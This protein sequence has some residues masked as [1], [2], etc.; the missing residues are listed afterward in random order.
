MINKAKEISI[1]VPKTA[2]LLEMRLHDKF[3]TKVREV[4]QPL[5]LVLAANQFIDSSGDI[6]YKDCRKIETFEFAESYKEY[7][8][9]LV[10][11]C[12]EINQAMDLGQEPAKKLYERWSFILK[13]NLQSVLANGLVYIMKQDVVAPQVNIWVGGALKEGLTW[14]AEKV[15]EFWRSSNPE[16]EPEPEN[17]AENEREEPEQ[18]KKKPE[19]KRP[20][21]E[22][23]QESRTGG[24]P[25]PKGNKPKDKP[26]AANDNVAND[27]TYGPQPCRDE[28]CRAGGYGSS[29]LPE[30]TEPR[31]KTVDEIL[32]KAN[33]DPKLSA[34]DREKLNSFTEDLQK[35]E[36]SLWEQF[37]NGVS[38]LWDS[39]EE[40]RIRKM[41]EKYRKYAD[42]YERFARENPELAEYGLSAV[43]IFAKTVATGG[44]AFI[45]SLGQE[46]TGRAIGE[47][48][49]EKF[50]EDINAGIAW[51]KEQFKLALMKKHPGLSAAEADNYAEM[52]LAAVIGGLA[53][54]GVLRDVLKHIKLTKITKAADIPDFPKKPEVKF[55]FEDGVNFNR[56]KITPAIK[57][58]LTDLLQRGSNAE[59]A[60]AFKA[61]TGWDL[62]KDVLDKVPEHI[63]KADIRLADSLDNNLNP[64]AGVRFEYKNARGMPQDNI[65]IMEGDPNAKWPSQRQDYVKITSNGKV[66]D[67]NGNPIPENNGIKPSNMQESHIPLHEWKQWSE[68]NKK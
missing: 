47:F 54:A 9:A 18:P 50:G 51:Q 23:A 42:K 28:S 62:P 25:K 5:M 8:Q 30:N 68:W 36:P 55:E 31:P 57:K 19:R 40:A 59:I 4:S 22:E 10:K 3:D 2:K 32:Q 34:A 15:M 6:N 49:K 58:E 26:A 44:V 16:T 53:G 38:N 35:D 33:Q 12:E 17:A 65:R 45:P 39:F 56:M 13:R 41:G 20:K 52:K 48:L 46:A 64:R 1:S 14:F 61:K 27:N 11:A 7:M 66:L 43:V 63:R 60:A 24:K 67:W 21:E 29:S 37:K